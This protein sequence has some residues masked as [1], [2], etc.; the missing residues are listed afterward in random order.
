MIDHAASVVV[1][2]RQRLMDAQGVTGTISVPVEEYRL[3][4]NTLVDLG[5]PKMGA[6]LAQPIAVKTVAGHLASIGSAL[7]ERDKTRM[8]P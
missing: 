7:D 5:A 2:A 6:N 1:L 8:G 3:L 4:L